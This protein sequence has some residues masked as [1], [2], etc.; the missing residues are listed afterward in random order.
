MT[1]DNLRAHAPKAML[2]AIRAVG[3]E[4]ESFGQVG[5]PGGVADR[6]V[7]DSLTELEP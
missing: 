7:Y 2:T 1:R 4:R 3:V 5:G 6:I